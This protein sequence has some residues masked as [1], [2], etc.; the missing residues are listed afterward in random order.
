MIKNGALLA[1]PFLTVSVNSAGER[2]LLGVAFDPNFAVN[3]FV[4]VYY[5]TASA[6]IHNRVSRFTAMGDVAAA[7]SE[8]V[9]LELENLSSATNHNGGAIHFGPDGKLY[10]AVGDNANGANSQTLAQPP[11]QDPAHQPRR[12]DPDLQSLLRHGDRREPRDLG[13]RPAQPVHVRVP[14]RH[15]PDVHQRRRPEHLG[16]DQRRHRRLELRLARHRRRDDRSPLPLADLLYGHGTSATTGCAITG[17]AFYNPTTLRVPERVHRRLLLRRLLQRLDPQARSGER[18][19]GHRVRNGNRQPGRPGGR[20][21]RQPLL[22]RARLRRRRLPRRATRRA[23]R[24]ASR[25]IPSS[26]TVLVPAGR[27]RSPW[28]PAARRRSRTSGSGTASTSPAPP[29]RATRLAAG[30]DRGQRRP[31]PRPRDERRP[32]PPSSNEAT[33]TVT[34]NQPPAATISQ[35]AAGTLYSA[36]QTIAYA[37][38]GSDPED[39]ESPGERVHL[40]GRLPPRHARPP[41]HRAH[42]AGRPSG[43]FVPLG[44]RPHGIRRLV[45][46]S[47]S[48]FATRAA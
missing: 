23:R 43:S 28:P 32:A 30:D 14:A 5:T 13:A 48:P 2:G 25:P 10:V 21:R 41:V 19:H 11:R 38:S 45:P 39:G 12:L 31:L 17:G 34:S 27:R 15:R 35:P 9:I 46:R 20:E 26:Q 40:A 22:P 44:R 6:P 36:G 33:L 7:G 24:R 42:V 29:L 47:T 4:Y 18:E 1:T 3:Q 16:G 37:G 8:V